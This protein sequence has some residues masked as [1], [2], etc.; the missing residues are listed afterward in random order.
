[1]SVKS[2]ITILR[3][4]PKK[5]KRARR[6]PKLQRKPKI[7]AVLKREARREGKLVQ[8]VTRL[9]RNPHDGAKLFVIEGVCSDGSQLRFN[10]SDKFGAPAMAARYADHKSAEHVLADIR[11]QVRVKQIPVMRVVPL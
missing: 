10:G 8:R 3:A 2:Q 5:A 9:A 6:A 1:M 7:G 11:R 4:N